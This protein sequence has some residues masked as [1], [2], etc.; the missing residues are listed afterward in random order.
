MHMLVGF[1]LLDS[2][3]LASKKLVKYDIKC[4]TSLITHLLRTYLSLKSCLVQSP[5]DHGKL[6]QMTSELAS[7]LA[8]IKHEQEYM[9]VRERIHRMS[10]PLLIYT[11]YYNLQF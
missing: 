5:T 3:M 1:S 6:A 8:G 10:E 2:G 7:G 11:N 9:E 4:S